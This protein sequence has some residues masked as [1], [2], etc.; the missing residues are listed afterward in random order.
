MLI[1][2]GLTVFVG[3]ALIQVLGRRLYTYAVT[4]TRVEIRLFARLPV[5]AIARDNIT[6]V[7]Q[8]QF[9]LRSWTSVFVTLSLGNRI[10]GDAVVIE[11]HGRFPRYIVLTPDDPAQMIALLQPT[12]AITASTRLP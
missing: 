6:D 11:Q 12:A 3:A 1:A 10:F 2:F 4:P 5:Y 8:W 7:A 9:S